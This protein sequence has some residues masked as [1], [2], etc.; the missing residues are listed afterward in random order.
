M[1]TENDV[2]GWLK[3][4]TLEKLQDLQFSLGTEGIYLSIGLYPLE[5]DA[6]TPQDRPEVTSQGSK[7]AINEPHT[8]RGLP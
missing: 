4:A 5:Q 6:P 1:I 3:T 7:S 2:V 8:Y